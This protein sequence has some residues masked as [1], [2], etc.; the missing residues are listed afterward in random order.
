[1]DKE[2]VDEFDELSLTNLHQEEWQQI[3]KKLR[4]DLGAVAFKSWLS[5]L[6]YLGINPEN[7]VYLALPSS[8][9][10]DWVVPHYGAQITALW[11][12]K[13]KGIKDIVIVVKSVDAGLDVF[14]EQNFTDT[15]NLTSNFVVRDTS[16]PLDPRFTFNN[17]IVGKSNEFAYAAARRL[18]ESSK[19]LFNPFF[20]FG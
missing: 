17:F 1:M 19:V 20:L 5:N 13:I 4:N 10:R 2:L 12:E 11:K 6:R 15:E 14:D 3:R 16:S 9:L 7:I 8:F 18:A